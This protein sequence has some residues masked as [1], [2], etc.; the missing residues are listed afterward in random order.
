MEKGYGDV[1]YWTEAAAH[2]H[3]IEGGNPITCTRRTPL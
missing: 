2:S 3:R 1:T